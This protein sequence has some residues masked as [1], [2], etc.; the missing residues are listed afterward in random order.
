MRSPSVWLF[1]CGGILALVNIASTFHRSGIPLAL[2]GRVERVDVRGEKH[3]GLDDVHLV[4]IAG[5]TTHLDAGVASQ[6]RVGDVVSKGAWS[7]TIATPRGQVELV[8][9][10]DFRRMA[11]SMPLILLLVFVLLRQSQRLSTVYGEPGGAQKAP[12]TR[13]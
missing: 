2:S 10:Q 1:V 9:S 8:L 7:T 13:R 5:R 4:T 6:L 3:P 11:V 12:S